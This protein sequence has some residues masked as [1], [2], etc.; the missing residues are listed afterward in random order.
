MLK[1]PC[2]EDMAVLEH[3][4]A[5]VISWCLYLNTKFSYRVTEKVT[6]KF[7]QGILTIMILLVIFPSKLL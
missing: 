5:E 7:H 4:C 3:F 6:N 2:Q 1:G